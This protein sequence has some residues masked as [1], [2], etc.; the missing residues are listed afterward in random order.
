MYHLEPN[1]NVL[2]T[3]PVSESSS[4]SVASMNDVSRLNRGESV[5]KV[6]FFQ[7]FVSDSLNDIL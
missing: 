1:K 4:E 3:T 6:K 2:L 5:K 7:M